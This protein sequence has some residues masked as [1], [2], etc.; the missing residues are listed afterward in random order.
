MTTKQRKS[1]AVVQDLPRAIQ[2]VLVDA[3]ERGDQAQIRAQML[4][5][6]AMS[7]AIVSF[8]LALSAISGPEIEEGPEV[9]ALVARALDRTRP[10]PEAIK[11][12]GFTRVTLAS[13]LRMGVD[14]LDKVAQGRIDLA[15]VPQRFFARL[16]EALGSTIEQARGC[17]E[18]AAHDVRPALAPALRRDD[19]RRKGSAAASEP[20]TS[21]DF[22]ALV[23]QNP[24]MSA[25][26]KAFW[27]E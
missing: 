8:M 12:A 18:L 14:L 24:N 25:D 16:S 15:T 17:V 1:A 19:P 21:A 3:H 2:M 4:A 6:P 22:A 13:R 5:N 10:L 26:D 23:R 9:D 20:T 11:K 7:D 27:L